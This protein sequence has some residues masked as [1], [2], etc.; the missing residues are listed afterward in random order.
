MTYKITEVVSNLLK[1]IRIQSDIVVDYN[2]M[3]AFCLI[4]V[5]SRA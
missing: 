1:L 5:L 3:R 4:A 2:I